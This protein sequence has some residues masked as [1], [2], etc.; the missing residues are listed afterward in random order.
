MYWLR[1]RHKNDCAMGRCN[2]VKKKKIIFL[3][4]FAHIYDVYLKRYFSIV[5]NIRTHTH[6][7]CLSLFL[8]LSTRRFLMILVDGPTLLYSVDTYVSHK[9]NV[10]PLYIYVHIHV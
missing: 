10:C 9:S 2:K 7:L 4:P 8:S 5:G 6:T 3:A 1:L